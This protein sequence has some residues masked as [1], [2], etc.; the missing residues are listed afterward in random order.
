MLAEGGEEEGP[1]VLDPEVTAL[2]DEV[3]EGL[4]AAGEVVGR[5]E[6]LFVVP[7]A[8]AAAY[9]CLGDDALA[10]DAEEEVDGRLLI[11]ICGS[12]AW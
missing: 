9:G 8:V 12:S 2:V 5:F 4:F 11:C 10:L 6:V 3:V 1:V 7:G